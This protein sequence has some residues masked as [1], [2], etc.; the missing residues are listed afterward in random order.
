[1]I[2]PNKSSPSSLSSSS[3]SMLISSSSRNLS[4]SCS[5]SPRFWFRFA[6]ISCLLACILIANA[7]CSSFVRR[8]RAYSR[9][10]RIRGL[11]LGCYLIN[12]QPGKHGDKETRRGVWI[13]LGAQQ[14]TMPALLRS[15]SL[16]RSLR[17]RSAS[18]CK[19]LCC[20]RSSSRLRSVSESG[21]DTLRRG[22]TGSC[23]S[24]AI[25]YIVLLTRNAGEL[26][27]VYFLGG[28]EG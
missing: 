10:Y 17:S 6:W 28:N 19:I 5:Y 15:C 26:G 12:E 4:V 13:L 9:F 8:V 21:L 27:L 11:W 25:W 14:L 1:M 7:S 23:V 18:A 24:R 16:A 22:V 3:L 20:S 2:F